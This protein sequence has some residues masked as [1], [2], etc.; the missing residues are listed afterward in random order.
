[1]YGLIG[2]KTGQAVGYKYS[3]ANVSKGLCLIRVFERCWITLANFVG[4]CHEVSVQIAPKIAPVAVGLTWVTF[5]REGVFKSHG[6]N[7]FFRGINRP[8][9]EGFF[10]NTILKSTSDC[11]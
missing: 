2:R 3:D 5:L 8:L 4:K 11:L 7:N 6:P 1:M 10:Y 9:A